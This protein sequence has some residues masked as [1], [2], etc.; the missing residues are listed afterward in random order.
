M[1]HLKRVFNIDGSIL[2]ITG[3]TQI[4]LHHIEMSQSKS[5]FHSLV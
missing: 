5:N 4:S 2:A 3:F 1:I